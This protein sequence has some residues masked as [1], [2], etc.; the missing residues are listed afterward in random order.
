MLVAILHGWRPPLTYSLPRIAAALSGRYTIERE[1][2]RGGMGMVYLAR[3]RKHERPVAIKVLPPDLAAALGPERFLREIGIVA[4]LSHPNILPLHD[5]GHAAGM[6]Y[7][8]S[9]WIEGES[10][11]ERLARSPTLSVEEAMAL[12]AEVADALAYAHARGVVHRD[13]KPENILLH[14]GHAL[15]ADF[16]IAKAAGDSQLTDSGQPLGTTGY[17]SPEQAAGSAAADGRSDIYSLG[18][19]L[20]EMLLTAAGDGSAARGLLARRFTEPL[21]GIHRL[22]P[23]VPPWIDPVLARALALSPGERYGRAE[24]FA[25]ALR[26]ARARKVSQPLRWLGALA[27]VLLLAATALALATRSV[28]RADSRAVVVAEFENRTGDSALAP[29][30][31]IASDYIARGLAAT[32]LV[33]EVYDARATAAELGRIHQPGPAPA[34]DLARRVGA[35]MVLWGNFYREGDSLH[36]ESQLVDAGTGRVILSPAPVVGL[37]AEK[38]RVVE[39]LRQRV[40][41][42]LAV[43]VS[44]DFGPWQ[45]PSVPPSYD[46]YLEVLAAEQAGWTFDFDD[47]ARHLT[48]AARLDSSYVG[49]R[50]ALAEALALAERCGEADSVVGGFEGRQAALSPLQRAQLAWSSASCRHDFEGQRLASQAMLASAPR[51]VGAA[52]L[53]SLAATQTNRPR[54]ALEVLLRS[55]PRRIGISGTSVAVYLDWLAGAYHAVG[56]HLRELATAREGL[57]AYPGYLHLEN[58]EGF[59]LAA[60]GDTAA[61]ES[62]AVAW[63]SRTP[64]E[65]AFSGQQAEC[66]ALELSA[67]GSAGPSRRLMHRVAA[68]YD[69]LGWERANGKDRLPCLWFLFSPDYYTGRWAEARGHY[70]AR[71]AQDSTDLLAHAA[72]GALAARQGDRAETR[73]MDRWLAARGDERATYAR[74]RMALLAGD[75]TAAAGFLRRA[76]GQGLHVPDHLDPDLAPLRADTAYRD[77]FRP[78]G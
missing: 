8:V 46:A 60:L 47:A 26:G 18:C 42:G 9:P 33:H 3:D 10:L 48:A 45:D 2:G 67:H 20:Y 19:V 73:R 14:Q 32:G 31:D 78:R 57:R 71:L 72:F 5:S 27:A 51:S 61:A 34:R 59:A 58:D 36:F 53:A 38:T 76:N 24:E 17:A 63:L 77:L 52:V 28:P 49:A 41:A 43:A 16:G 69:T 74:A 37:A 68:W 70:R 39:L 50:T 29:V 30:G 12:G 56:D 13:V 66:V 64:D 35:G 23:T 55:D 75:T 40:M 25:R 1:L 62:L 22:R 7:F 11:R 15:L 6:P 21:P 4:R 44:R 54:E 65:H